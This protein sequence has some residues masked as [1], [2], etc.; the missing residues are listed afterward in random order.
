MEDKNL[1]I[2]EI[3]VLITSSDDDVVEINPNFLEYFELDELIEMRDNLIHKKQN[4][5][6]TS[7]DFVNELYEK[8]KKDEI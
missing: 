5:K 3:K 8:T 1:I 6:E 4:F 7:L 2:E